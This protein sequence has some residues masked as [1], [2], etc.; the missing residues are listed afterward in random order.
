MLKCTQNGIYLVTLCTQNK[1]TQQNM[2]TEITSDIKYIGVDDTSLDLFESQYSVPEGMAY[3][4]YLIL[5]EKVAILDTVDGRTADEWKEK[6]TEALTGRTPDY[7]VVHHMEPDHAS[8]IAEVL[9]KYPEIK[10]VC[11][12]KAVSMLGN[13]F[14]GVDFTDK[15]QVVKDG[16]ELCLGAHTLKFFTAMMVHWPEVIV[17]YDIKDKILFSADAFGKFGALCNETENWIDEAR[18]YYFNVCGKYGPQVQRLLTKVINLDIQTICSTHGPVLKENIGYYVDLYDKWSQ[19]EPETKGV[20][21]AY[22]SIHGGTKAAAEY[23]ADVLREKGAGEVVVVDLSRCDMA[24]A[25]ED[26]FRLSSCVFASASYDANVFP[27]MYDFI[28]HLQLKAWQG[29]RVGIIENGSWA[30]SAARIM[31]KMLEEMKAIEIVEPQVTIWSR[32]KTKDKEAMNELAN[33][34]ISE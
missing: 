26:A 7:L 14:D 32:M 18:R 28:H 29:R 8:L 22:A 19:Y 20:L 21:V 33:A 11:S 27:P 17:S 1:E 12:E 24:G 30:P 6:L 3:N 9:A 31:R 2:I 16:D 4:S 5:D 10:I 34:I 23:M 25:L 15:V 13:F